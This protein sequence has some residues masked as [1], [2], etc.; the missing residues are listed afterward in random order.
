MVTSN[1]D[2]VGRAIELLAEGLEPFVEQHMSATVP[3]NADWLTAFAARD[4]GR[5][6]VSRNDPQLLLRVLTEEW[7]VF[8]DHL[9]RVEQSFATELRDHRN[10]WAHNDAFSAEDTSRALDTAERLLTS[11]GAVKQADDVRRM[12][13]DHQRAMFEQETRRIVK[14]RETSADLAGQGLKPWREVLTPHEDVATGNFSASEFAADLHVV[15]KGEGAAEYGDPVEFF[16][17]TYLTE[18]LRKLLDRAVKRLGGDPNAGPITNTQTN[19][20]GGKTHSMLA[21]W[22]L[23]SGTPIESFPQDVQELVAGRP[24]PKRV[25]R[26]A[27]VGTHLTPGAPDTKRDGTVVRTL[28]GEL[29]WQLGRREAYDLVADADRTATNPGAVMKDLFELY[30]PC[31][32]LIDEWVAY[33]RQLW[34]R[35]DLPAGTFETQFTFAQSLTEIAKTVPGTMVVISIPAS[36]DPE[37]TGES[38]G[39]GLEV[40]G[41][42][43]QAALERLQNV[44]RRIAE[45]WQPADA[46]ESFEIVRR[47]LFSE[48]NAATLADISVVARQ[49]REFYARHPGEFPREAGHPA[50]E[51]RIKRAY[52]IHPELFDRLYQDW[53]T[54]ERFQRT[55][56]VLRLMST[57]VHALWTAQDA[58]PMILPGTVPLDLPTVTSELTQY[59]PDAW[60][61]I[62]DTDVDGTESTSMKIDLERPTFGQRAVTRRLARATFLGAAP[63]LRNANRGVEKQR[64]WLGAAI[65]GDTVGNFGSALELLSQR[66]T[67]LYAEGSRYWF[68]THPSVTRTAADY[69]D[70]LRDKPELVW[71]EIIERLRSEQR[72]RGGFAAVHVAPDSTA[73][74]PD[75][76][77]VRLVIVHPRH[78]HG[79]GDGGSAAMV[80]A[81]EAFERRGSAQRTNRNMI[82]FLAADSKRYDELDDAVRTNLAW[83]W[84]DE[85]T[86]ELNLSPQQAKQVTT[87]CEHSDEA[88]ASRLAQ[89][90]HWAIVP[91]QPDPSRPATLTVEKADGA[92]DRIADRVTEKLRRAGTLTGE[93]AAR[94]IRTDL[95]TCLSSVWGRGHIAVGELWSYYCRYPYLTRLRDRSVLDDGV[96]SVLS[97]FTWEKEFA[98]ADGYDDATGQYRGL[99][100]P[101]GDARFGQLTDSTLLVVP[102]VAIHQRETE[103]ETPA[104]P[105]GEPAGG[106]GAGPAGVGGAAAPIPGEP[107]T[108]RNRRYFGVYSINPERFGRDLT[109]LSQEILQ[110]LTSVE[111]AQI[112][113]SVEIHAEHPDGFAEDK[114]RIISENAHTLR[115]DQSAFEDN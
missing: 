105:G 31:L 115:F 114:V 2:R 88:V 25:Q 12:R 67:Y 92:G 5:R 46:Q 69:A 102:A 8:R 14:Q 9:S 79:R 59:L 26:V 76:E 81:Q 1:R 4:G 36:H 42:N 111:G 74:V 39:S 45:P 104:E 33:A 17:R 35:E 91:E 73:E 22:H 110:P 19:F 83:R 49:Y 113:I 57:V 3:A 85:R 71:Q 54:L 65:P 58:A 82:V 21:V 34:G 38:G 32:I 28:W 70:G 61:P 10:R 15:A 50:Y 40:G 37:K 56:G 6:P 103:A 109:R 20:G 23:F 84:I 78:P 80:F 75:G 44:V 108:P 99:V 89:T 7:R 24:L 66:S 29:A 98:L 30:S 63:T 13:L 68:D 100:L 72:A 86:D 18:G 97:S 41:P 93:V 112:H 107:E 27:L 55:R 11:T 96:S 53:S 47:R 106:S 48:P 64:M 101:G 16:R 94:A 87:N 95:D 60:K 62:I 77:E 52:P 43:G 51:D 90:Y